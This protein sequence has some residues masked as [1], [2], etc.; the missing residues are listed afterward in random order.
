M[1]K[2]V[3]LTASAMLMASMAT[4]ASAA[5]TTTGTV[6]NANTTT[7][8]VDATPTQTPAT[9]A[10]VTG[11][12]YSGTAVKFVSA[13]RGFSF[14][15]PAV[16]GTDVATQEYTAEQLSDMGETGVYLVRFTYTP[17]GTTATGEAMK[18]VTI[19]TIRGYDRTAWNSMTNQAALGTA[20]NQDGTTVYVLSPVTSNPFTNQADKERFQSLIDN[21]RT[22][23]TGTFTTTVPTTTTP[24]T[25][26]A[27][28]A[29]PVGSD[30]ALIPTNDPSKVS[31]NPT[32]TIELTS[33]TPFYKSPGG[34]MIGYLGPQKLDTTGN[35]T[36]D[37]ATGQWVEIYTWMGMAWIVVE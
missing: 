31:V 9:N 23:I 27:P 4:A 19:A 1:K 2:L 6:T 3:T 34:T 22:G 11:S 14:T 13:N 20:L 25:P 18:P 7:N 10:T 28:P 17:T 29:V 15:Q 16:W 26:T 5:E 32:P 37:P 8:P 12:T 30:T 33:M 35:G 36:T 24:T 21:V